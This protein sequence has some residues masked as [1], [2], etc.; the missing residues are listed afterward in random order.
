MSDQL[1]IGKIYS[2]YNEDNIPF[3]T[4]LLGEVGSGGQY[5]H[6]W[7]DTPKFVLVVDFKEVWR[8]IDEELGVAR[9]HEI[10]EVKNVGLPWETIQLPVCLNLST[11]NL[12]TIIADGD[13]HFM[14][15][16]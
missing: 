13:V 4:Y 10:F 1:E 14:E 11:G 7:V 16:T 5:T 8:H 12:I 2:L 3:M 15:L 9:Y 6:N